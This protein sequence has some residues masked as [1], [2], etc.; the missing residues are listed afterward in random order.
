MT[1]L[2]QARRRKLARISAQ[3]MDG[4]AFH[5]STA[6]TQA[7]F[8]I[9]LGWIMRGSKGGMITGLPRL[10]KTCAIKWCVKAI[11]KFYG[12]SI[13][14]LHVPM[15]SQDHP[16]EKDFFQHLLVIGKHTDALSG[17]AYEKRDKLNTMLILMA[18][19][20]PLHMVIVSFDEAQAFKLFHWRW[21]IDVANEA[22]ENKVRVFFIFLDSLNFRRQRKN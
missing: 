8:K 4:V 17:T 3:I 10:G 7:L 21:V 5:L 11:G 12:T 6:P 19:R 15:R 14:Y 20:S 18:K 1:A 9:I 22:I 2:E 13:P 16:G